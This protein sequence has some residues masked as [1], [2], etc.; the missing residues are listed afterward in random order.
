MI[1][2][3]QGEIVWRCQGQE[4]RACG[5]GLDVGGRDIWSDFSL[6]LFGRANSTSLREYD[7]GWNVGVDVG[8]RDIEPSLLWVLGLWDG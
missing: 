1:N 3:S 6:V 2:K 4:E 5:V 7:V 8:G